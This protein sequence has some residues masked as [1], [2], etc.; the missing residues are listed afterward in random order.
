MQGWSQQVWP[1]EEAGADR[2]ICGRKRY[3]LSEAAMEGPWGKWEGSEDMEWDRER[4]SGPATESTGT[5]NKR[6]LQTNYEGHIKWKKVDPKALRNRPSQ[7]WEWPK[8]LPKTSGGGQE[9]H[10]PGLAEGLL[11]FRI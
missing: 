6:P 5:A 4:Q 8:N 1:R 3:F 10:L 7:A 2:S 9:A 11:S